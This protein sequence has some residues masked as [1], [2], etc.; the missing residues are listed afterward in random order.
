MTNRGQIER[1]TERYE[2]AAH[3][4]QTAIGILGGPRLTE[5]HMRT[6]IDMGKAGLEGLA[7]LLMEKGLF[8][9][10][11]YVAALAASAEREADRYEHEL[12]IKWGHE[13]PDALTS[14]IPAETTTAS[15]GEAVSV[16][17]EPSSRP[18]RTLEN[19]RTAAFKNFP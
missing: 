5:K 2:R 19:S 3:R 6:G 12:S 1:D 18:T 13:H 11:E 4:V 7:T 8:K 17:P 16:S 15:R 14:A 10:E 9:M